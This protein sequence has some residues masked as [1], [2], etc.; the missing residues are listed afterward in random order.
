MNFLSDSFGYKTKLNN[1]DVWHIACYMQMEMTDTMYSNLYIFGMLLT[2][3][4]HLNCFSHVT[5]NSV[6]FFFCGKEK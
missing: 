1:F 4:F 3:N 5:N 2:I 6:L